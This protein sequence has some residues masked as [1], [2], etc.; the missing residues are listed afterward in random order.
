MGTHDGRTW[1]ECSYVVGT[2]D[3]GPWEGHPLMC[4]VTRG[5]RKDPRQER[6]DV[7]LCLRHMREVVEGSNDDE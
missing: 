4:G 2:H 1:L 7:G 5:T 3:K 6:Y